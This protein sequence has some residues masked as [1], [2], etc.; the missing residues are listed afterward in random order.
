MFFLVNW[1]EG[2]KDRVCAHR[3]EAL[4]RDVPGLT[5]SMVEHPDKHQL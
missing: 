1:L 5:A 3:A 4:P 2:K